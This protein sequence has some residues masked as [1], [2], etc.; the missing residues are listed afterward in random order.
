M[1]SL[2]IADFSVVAGAE[3][4]LGEA[5]RIFRQTG[6]CII[7]NA[8]SDERAS[9]VLK[10]CQE[11][12]RKIL[13]LDPERMGWCHD[14]GHYSFCAASQSG[15]MLHHEAWSLLLACE[16]TFSALHAILP[17]GFAFCGGG[18]DFVLAGTEKYQTLHADLGPGQ[19]PPEYRV[20]EAPPQIAVNFIVQTMT[21]KNGPMRVIP[22]RKVIH[23]QQDIPPKFRQEP[24]RYLQS[25]LFPLPKGAAILRDLRLWHGGTPN[26]SEET[27]F[28]PSVEVF[29]AKYA[30]FIFEKSEEKGWH[31]NL[32]SKTRRCLPDSLFLQLPPAVRERCQEIRAASPVPTGF[33]DFSRPWLDKKGSSWEAPKEDFRYRL[34]KRTK[35]LRGS[36]SSSSMSA[37]V[38]LLGR[39]DTLSRI[40]FATLRAAVADVASVVAKSARVTLALVLLYR[41]VQLWGA[42]L[43]VFD[44]LVAGT[45][46]T[47]R[48]CRY[49]CGRGPEIEKDYGGGLTPDPG[50]GGGGG[51]SGFDVKVMPE[52]LERVQALARQYNQN[53]SVAQAVA[54]HMEQTKNQQPANP[55]VEAFLAQYPQIQAHAAARLRALPKEAQT[56][57]LIRGGLGSARDPT[58]MLLGRIRQVDP[59][60]TTWVPHTPGMQPFPTQSQVAAQQTMVAK[61]APEPKAPQPAVKDRDDG[62]YDALTALAEGELMQSARMQKALTNSTAKAVPK[63][64]LS[65]WRRAR[66]QPGEEVAGSL[67]G[68]LPPVPGLPPLGPPAQ[69][70]SQ[71]PPPLLAPMPAPP[72]G[73]SR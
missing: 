65:D 9:E 17:D 19:V 39:G 20:D 57:V 62:E 36:A 42:L 72:N 59:F 56:N 24:D 48:S 37:N 43:A 33:R 3:G 52:D 73:F 67:P 61:I 66:P 12:E 11:A 41:A 70:A 40:D 15:H 71:L 13:E 30:S 22:G 45:G 28:L 8:L 35:D 44:R 18:G 46:R 51:G 6:F 47:L 16:T 26:S 27:C 4:W 7:L 49:G 29:S 38:E 69:E 5:V 64:V 10:A 53:K 34:Q 25:K 21:E 68:S 23:G 31:W 50:G 54:L 2:E 32:P 58:A 60:N 14:P 55:E 1:S 63:P